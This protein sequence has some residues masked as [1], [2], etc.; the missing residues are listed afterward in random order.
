MRDCKWQPANKVA[1]R[2]KAARKMKGKLM[3]MWFQSAILTVKV[4]LSAE[5]TLLYLHVLQVTENLY[6]Q[7]NKQQVLSERACHLAI[8]F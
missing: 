4:P 7:L 5:Q 2:E 6:S 8:S 1:R 3:L